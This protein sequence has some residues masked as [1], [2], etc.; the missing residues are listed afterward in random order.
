LERDI[1]GIG[2]LV[3]ADEDEIG[4]IGGVD[5]HTAIAAGPD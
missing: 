2:L 3:G 5:M 1:G 4:G